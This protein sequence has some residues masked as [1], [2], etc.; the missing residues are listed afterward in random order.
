MSAFI[1]AAMS[2]WRRHLADRAWPGRQFLISTGTFAVA[3][4]LVGRS[5]FISAGWNRATISYTERSLP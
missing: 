1:S 4:S 2:P 3:Y 5:L